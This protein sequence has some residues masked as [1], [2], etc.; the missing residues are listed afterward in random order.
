MIRLIMFRISATEYRKVYIIYSSTWM[1][2]QYTGIM[3]IIANRIHRFRYH[4]VLCQVF[5]AC[6]QIITSL[7]RQNSISMHF[8]FQIWLQKCYVLAK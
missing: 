5:P 6:V 1:K 8:V 7:L 2:Y 4:N 3:I